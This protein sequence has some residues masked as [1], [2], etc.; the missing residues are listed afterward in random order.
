M[1]ACGASAAAGAQEQGYIPL[2]DPVTRTIDALVARGALPRLSALERPYR[3]AEV[4]GAVDSALARAGEGRPALAPHGWYRTVRSVA[5]RYAGGGAA[6]EIAVAVWLTPFLTAQSTGG[7]ELML[8]DTLAGVYPGAHLRLAATL[9][10]VAAVTRLRVDRA[11]RDDAEYL[12]KKDRAVVARMEDAY[13]AARWRFAAL[14][15]GRVARNWGPAAYDGLQIGRY[16][17]TYDHVALVLGVDA[18]HLTTV[19]ARLDDMPVVGTASDTAIAQRYMTAHRLAARWRS[20]EAA[21]G[22]QVVYGGPGRGFEPSL[23]NPVSLLDLNQY[24]EGELLN[25]SYALDLALRTRGR[26]FYAVQ[27]MLDD[28]QIDEC[29]PQCEEPASWG[30]TAT[31]EALP[32]GLP[33]DGRAF[34]SYTR[35]TNLVYRTASPWVRMTFR[36]LALGRGQT[37]YDEAR[38]GIELAPALGGPLRLYAALRRQGEGDY[39]LPFPPPAANSRTPAIFAGTVM[40]VA[41]F[42]AQWSMSGPFEGVADLGWQRVRNYHHQAGA[43]RDG[44]EGRLVVRVPLGVSARGS[45]GG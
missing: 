5:A 6:D 35:V 23:A 33:L 20:F 34:A 28:F 22:E 31:A 29:G 21:V 19:V 10:N 7:R 27:A 14:D 26:G 3:A 41:R 9:G 38:A 25:V 44:F 37:D 45:G 32:L 42:G 15:V 18:L 13:L 17:D 43:S 4:R 40:R 2:D 12:G 24:S 8:A 39:R 1:L 36:E 30:L 16:A 11:L